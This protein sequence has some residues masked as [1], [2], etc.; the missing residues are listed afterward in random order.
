MQRGRWNYGEE[1]VGFWTRRT[2]VMN[3]TKV[4]RYLGEELMLLLDACE[5]RSLGDV[6]RRW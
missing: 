4:L 6:V 3:S 1:Q 2:E 5:A